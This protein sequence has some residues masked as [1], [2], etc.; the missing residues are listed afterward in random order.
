MNYYIDGN[1]EQLNNSGEEHYY[2]SSYSSDN[3]TYIPIVLDAEEQK[4]IND[5]A[6]DEVVGFYN[7]HEKLFK[8][9]EEKVGV[10]VWFFEQFRMYF[11]YRTFFLKLACI[12]KFLDQNPNGKVITSDNRLG[13]FFSADRLE[14]R[15]GIG[16]KP[17]DH[18]FIK[19]FFFALSKAKF[20]Y[21]QEKN[22]LMLSRIEDDV[23]GKDQRFGKLET[24]YDKL[25]NREQFN[26]GKPLL[27]DNRFYLKS[28]N[29]DHIM[30]RYFFGV[31]WL[32]DLWKF[33][34][35]LKALTGS[36]RS[37]INEK[38]NKGYLILGL[39]GKNT[40]S[41]FVYYLRYR[42]FHRFFRKTNYKSVSF[43]NENSAQQKAVQY[44]AHQ[45]GV[46]IYGIQHG[47]IY[48][49]HPAYMYGK[50]ETIPLLPDVTFVWGNYFKR[51]LT[52]AGGY[53]PE[54]VVTSGRI[55][56]VNPKKAKHPRL[57]SDKKCLVYATQPQPDMNLRVR[58][59]KAV[60]NAVKNNAEK[61][62]LVLRPH[63][64]EQD[65]TFF[66][67]IAKE[68]GFEDFIIDRIS[69]LN[70]HFEM[71]DVLIT[72]YSTVGAEFV[73][74]YKPLLVLDFLSADLVRYIE[75]GVGIPVRSE[76]E[77]IE[78]LREGEL[79]INQSAFDTFVD[80]Y[81]YKAG[82]EA[83]KIVSETVEMPTDLG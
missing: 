58:E 3:T 50:Y 62:H 60:F 12:Q 80:N 39:F 21:K 81:F 35:N 73:P 22:H 37:K 70:T 42:A 15:E 17:K 69:D 18:G 2:S 4:R 46:K 32:T 64:A 40:M 79:K 11:S 71:A 75:Q 1:F 27:K 31:L 19:E 49:L 52:D 9:F 47:A 53:R 25:V 54:Q 48:D 78:V 57:E 23:E 76:T 66:T 38:D 44:A 51:L 83:V 28:K 43:I 65:D 36:L 7:T 82:K 24:H 67:G 29:V 14:M 34:K 10:D 16:G 55:S 6:F 68:V 74:Y 77:M 33:R 72:S 59:L 26:L 13:R 8:S 30:G 61:Y 45:N 20:S 56:A 63:P 5:S 41:Y